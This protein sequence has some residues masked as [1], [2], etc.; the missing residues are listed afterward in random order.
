MWG[1]KNAPARQSVCVRERSAGTVA[2][3]ATCT[4]SLPRR[5]ERTLTEVPRASSLGPAEVG[6]APA[7]HASRATRKTC[8]L[9]VIKAAAL[10]WPIAPLIGLVVPDL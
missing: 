5:L 8:G 4:E 6:D 2:A 9:G 1:I 10:R 7:G 3:G